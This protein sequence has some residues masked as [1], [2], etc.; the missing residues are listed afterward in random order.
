MSAKQINRDYMKSMMLSSMG[1]VVTLFAVSFYIDKDATAPIVAA[2]LTLIPA[3]FVML[4]LRAVWIYVHRVDE[5]QRFFLVK[6]M[7]IG[8][9]AV[10]AVSGSWGLIEMMSNDLPKLPIFWMFPL[11]F[12]VFGLSTCFGPGRGMGCKG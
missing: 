8:L 9:F 3:F 10:L 11:F 12:G 2:V 7:M 4:M 5:A 1:Y 6:S